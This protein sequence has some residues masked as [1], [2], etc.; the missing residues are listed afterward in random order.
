MP[1]YRL[2]LLSNSKCHGQDYLEHAEKAIR[3]FLGSAQ[4]NVLFVPYAGV[5]VTWDD[6][7]ARVADR[8]ANMGCRIESI[9]AVGNP[10]AAVEKAEV[11]AVGGG[12]TFH[13]LRHLYAEDLIDAIRRRAGQ[14][15]PY[16]GWSAGS[17]LTCP[18][19]KTTND[20]PITEPPTFDALGLI[21]FQINPHYLDT[22]PTTHQG[23]TRE[24]R[25]LEFVEANPDTYVAG[26]RE[27]SIFR[28]E[29]RELALLGPNRVRVFRKGM[30]TREY[31]P[32]DDLQF[33][34]E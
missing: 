20:M 28:V 29:G 25:I 9:H 14:G 16:I 34:M 31:A 26:L 24:Q 3:D 30:E 5:T 32:G 13:L 12:N 15:V 27:G 10:R 7:A 23:E 8:F 19:I 33:L 6:Y 21:P 17:N 2:L 4:R 18:T 22:H 11:I 1:S